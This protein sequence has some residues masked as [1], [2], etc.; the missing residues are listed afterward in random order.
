LEKWT[1]RRPK[2]GDLVLIL[3]LAILLLTGTPP[4]A[5]GAEKMYRIGV[6]A[7]EGMHP[8]QS[9]KDRLLELGW[10]EGTISASVFARRK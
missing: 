7:P 1:P 4:F 10:I 6:L 2:R 9:F 8:I 5:E 3:T